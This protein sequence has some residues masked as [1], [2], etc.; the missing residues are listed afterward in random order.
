MTIDSFADYSNR[1]RMGYDITGSNSLH[2]ILLSNITIYIP[3]VLPLLI[4]LNININSYYTIPL[5]MSHTL[6]YC[7]YYISLIYT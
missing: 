6:Y 5:S 3:L 7:D 1:T 4:P 2:S